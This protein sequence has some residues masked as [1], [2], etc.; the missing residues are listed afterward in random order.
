MLTSGPGWERA[1]DLLFCAVGYFTLGLPLMWWM[2]AGG[3]PGV[4]ALLIIWLFGWLTLYFPLPLY[5]FG[6]TL[7]K[8]LCGVRIVRRASGRPI[9]F[10][11]ALGREWFWLVS[12]VVPVLGLLNA[13]WCSWDR[14]YQQCLHDKVTGTMAVDR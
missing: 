9:G 7:G 10:W 12:L 5:L 6:S 13:L 2:D 14:P 4:R 8:R 11:Q 1:L 3:G